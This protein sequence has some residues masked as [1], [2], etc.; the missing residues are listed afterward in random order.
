MEFKHVQEVIKKIGEKAREQY[1]DGLKNNPNKYGNGRNSIAS[2]K[3]FNS[4]NY[5][6]DISDIDIKLYFTAED[7]WINIENGSKYT[8]KLPPISAIRNW[9]VNRNISGKNLEWKIQR[10]IFKNGIKAKPYLKDVKN[11]IKDKYKNE[12]EE[13]FKKDM[14][15]YLKTKL[16]ETKEKQNANK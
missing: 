9:M 12:I 8:N 15:E 6:I 10:S 4:V 1:K 13:A 14:K 2:G 7:Y 5:R 3:L 16:K 11:I